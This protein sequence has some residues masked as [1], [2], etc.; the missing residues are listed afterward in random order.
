MD[1]LA[2]DVGPWAGFKLTLVMV[3]G[4]IWTSIDCGA[5]VCGL[6]IVFTRGKDSLLV[7]M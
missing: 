3:V 1:F 2:V 5:I 7:L 6:V 4:N